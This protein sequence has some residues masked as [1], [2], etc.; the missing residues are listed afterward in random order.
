MK[1]LPLKLYPSRLKTA[2]LLVVS[3][4]FTIGGI[5][6]IQDG[7]NKGWFV[8]SFFALCTLVFLLM[9]LPNSTYLKISEEGIETKSL[10]KK[11][12]IISWDVIDEFG[13][14]YVGLNK[15][16]TL[17]FN[18]NYTKQKLGREIANSISGFDGA[19]PNTYG[20]SAS[21][22]AEL[23]NEYKNKFS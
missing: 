6:M 13:T 21:K 12:Q 11:S 2:L 20:M 18:E 5:L 3:L 10:F 9:L 16:V 7:K 15:M 1:Q 23:L 14:S 4:V 22:L 17:N 8:F 19:L